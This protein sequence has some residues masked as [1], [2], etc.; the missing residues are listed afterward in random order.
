MLKDML[1]AG[2]YAAISFLMPQ[3]DREIRAFLKDTDGFAKGICHP[4]DNR[5]DELKK[6]NIGW[7]RFDICRP[8]DDDGR[9]TEGYLAFK[10]RARLYRD[11]GFRIMGVTPCP[12][13]YSS[14]PFS[15]ESSPYRERILKDIRYLAEDLQGLVS[16]FQV[17]NEMQVEHFRFPLSE[18]ESVSFL[19]IQL[20]ALADVK[21]T[22]KVGFNLQNF[23]LFSYLRKMRPFLRYCDYVGLDLYLGC[24][25]SLTKELYVYD[26]VT[27]F[28][29]GYAG[30]PVWIAEFGYISTGQPKSEAEKREILRRYGAESEE[31]ARRDIRAFIQRLPERFCDHLMNHI[32]YNS[33]EELADKLFGTE[34]KNHLYCELPSGVRLK[35]YEHSPE[36]QARFMR[37][38]IRR[39]RRLPFVCGA[40][41]YCCSD[42]PR[43]YICGQED[44]PVET[45][46]GLIDNQGRKKPAWYAVKDAFR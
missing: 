2:L 39:F 18:E 36:D 19:G 25:E 32:E 17:A 28:I 37:D 6:A 9:E 11:A 42:S 16:A 38:A 10:R 5:T 4:A 46:W 12:G 7:V 30:K 1:F 14:A 31:E 45:A 3:Q 29:R 13:S 41:V 34:L 15:P 22:I 27:R 26:F 8:L 23:T 43:C 44:C 24:F 33:D 40:F 35:R 21:K 20:E